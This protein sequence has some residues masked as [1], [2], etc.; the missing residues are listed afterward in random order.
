M[1]V[2]LDPEAS[3][4]EITIDGQPAKAP[5]GA[6]AALAVLLFRGG[7]IRKAPV[8]GDP[9]APYCLMGTCFECLVEIDGQAGVRACLRP[10][11]QGM[12]IRTEIAP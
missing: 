4:V 11:R 7:A 1:F 10:V 5:V 12:A 2:S 8:E 9:R 3:T 6:S